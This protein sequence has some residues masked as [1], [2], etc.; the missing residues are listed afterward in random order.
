LPAN[1]Q[2]APPVAGPNPDDLFDPAE[3]NR[4]HHGK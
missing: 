4:L 2:Q 3:F 1:V